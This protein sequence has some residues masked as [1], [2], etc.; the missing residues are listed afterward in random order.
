M[1]DA[2]PRLNAALEGRYATERELVAARV[3]SD[4]AFRVLGRTTL[5]EVPS[6][7]FA[8]DYEAG[9]V[10]DVAADGRFLMARQFDSEDVI[11]TQWMLINNWFEELRQRVG[12]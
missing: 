4:G 9:A 3:A 5:F 1:S 8:G 2:I 11:D 7:F 6:N 12:N 10:Y